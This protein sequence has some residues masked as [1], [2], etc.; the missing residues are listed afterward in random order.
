MNYSIK[1][2]LLM[3]LVILTSLLG[4][5]EWNGGNHTF[6]FVAEAELLSKLFKDPGSVAHPLTLL[7]LIGQFLLIIQLFQ[8]K[9]RKLIIYIC[10]I[11]LGLLLG[12]MFAI[13]IMSLNI[14]I[15]AST[16]PFLIA[17]FFTIKHFRSQDQSS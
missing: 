1:G 13:G 9:P 14:K 8:K 16:V 12:L 3:A 15:A 10:I 5:L 17:S 4:Y 6:L 7:P 11:F 2:K